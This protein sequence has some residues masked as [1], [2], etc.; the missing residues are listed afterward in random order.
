MRVRR[1]LGTRDDGEADQRI[2]QLNRLLADRSYWS[3]TTRARAER[4]LDPE[5][6]RAF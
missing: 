2:E 5:V 4:E 3:P 1:D 6:V